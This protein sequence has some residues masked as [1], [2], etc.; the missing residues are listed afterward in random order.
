MLKTKKAITK[1]KA[2]NIIKKDLNRNLNLLSIGNPFKSFDRK[3]FIPSVLSRILMS[4]VTIFTTDKL[5]WLEKYRGKIKDTHLVTYYANYDLVTTVDD[6]NLMDLLNSEPIKII[7]GSINL[8][9]L[10]RHLG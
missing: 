2:D 10:A 9:I 4:K 3:E 8:E 5:S 7:E 6:K 1:S